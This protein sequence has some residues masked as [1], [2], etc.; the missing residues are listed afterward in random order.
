VLLNIALAILN[1]AFAEQK[2]KLSEQ[3]DDPYLAIKEVG[4]PIF[5]R[6]SL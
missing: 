5:F 1:D 4:V 2:K 6:F 3:D